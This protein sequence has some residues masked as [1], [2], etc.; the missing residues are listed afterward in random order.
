MT[1]TLLNKSVFGRV[2]MKDLKNTWDRFSNIH[3]M[4]Y[5]DIANFI[6]SYVH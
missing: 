5:L 1:Y 2:K 4:C 6:E 3:T